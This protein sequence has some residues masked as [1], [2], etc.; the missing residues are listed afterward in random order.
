[1]LLALWL[2]EII[3]SPWTGCAKQWKRYTDHFLA[4]RN[5]IFTRTSSRIDFQLFI[6]FLFVSVTGFLSASLQ[7]SDRHL[8]FAGSQLW[9]HSWQKL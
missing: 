2:P 6:V 9:R 5:K 1:M 8:R 7:P 4:V 3:N